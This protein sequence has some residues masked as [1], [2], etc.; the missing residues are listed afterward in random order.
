M[1]YEVTLSKVGN[2]QF[3]YFRN[4]VL[5]IKNVCHYHQ[6][7]LTI[8]VIFELYTFK[9][10]YAVSSGKFNAFIITLFAHFLTTN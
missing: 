5:K 9:M 7:N 4:N 8:L 6:N 10:S 3:L 2:I 1:F